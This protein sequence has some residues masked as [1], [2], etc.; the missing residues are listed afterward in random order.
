[1]AQTNE[2]AFVPISPLFVIANINHPT[3]R[4]WLCVFD[5][6]EDVDLVRNSWP[7]ADSGKVL[8]TSRNDIVSIDP[9]SNGM[10]IE[11]F[12][13]ASGTDLIL[14]HVARPSYNEAE[15]QAARQL[16]K[17]LG[18]LALALVVMSSQIR[19][20]KMTISAFV[21]LYEKHAAK[22]NNEKLG[23]ESYY[24]LSLTTCW[25]TAFDYLNPSARRL[26]GIIAHLG[27]DALPE[28]LFHPSDDSKLP[29][30]MEFC[31][32]D[33]EYECKFS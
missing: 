3:D 28:D 32:D 1:M 22:L 7:V 14:Q 15:I 24:N 2:Y 5:K 27:P 31:S 4:T 6:V 23:I 10:E 26:L 12:D 19:S 18:G 33:W 9:S 13:E 20:R 17:R 16:A 8:V 11:V 21:Q 25:K 29:E 30:G